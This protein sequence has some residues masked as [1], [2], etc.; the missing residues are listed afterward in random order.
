MEIVPFE[1][2]FE[3]SVVE[4]IVGIQRGEFGVAI[5]AEQQPDLRRI[6]EYYQTGSGNFWVALS[7]AQV[8]GTIALLDIGNGQAAL[9][10]M[11]VDAK[12]RGAQAGAA[13]RLLDALL[14]WANERG[15]REIF[16]GTTSQFVAA[17]R[18]YEKNGFTELRRQSLPA[19]FP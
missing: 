3:Q 12:H 15:L 17:H 11:F 9:R 6:P 13:R 4:L 7:A 16:L 14:R 18:F 5:T 8:V 19:A 10:K 2:R 1:P